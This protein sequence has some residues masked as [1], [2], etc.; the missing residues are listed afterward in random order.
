MKT[1]KKKNEKEQRKIKIKPLTKQLTSESERVGGNIRDSTPG[2]PG[3]GGVVR[4]A[5]IGV[6]GCVGLPARQSHRA[7]VK[8]R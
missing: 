1:K 4:V 2:A 6:V 5:M 3:E 8:R 7:A